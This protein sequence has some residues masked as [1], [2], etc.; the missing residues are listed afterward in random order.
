MAD[1]KR[2]RA[3]LRH[4]HVTRMAPK[5]TEQV[6]DGG[7]LYWVVKGMISARQEIL[8]LEPFVDADGIGRCKIWLGRDGGRGRAAADARLP[9]LALLSGE[10]RAAGHRR[11]PARLRRDAGGDAPRAGVA[12]APCSRRRTQDLAQNIY[13]TPE[14]FDGYS[15][16]DRSVRGLDG[17]SR[18]AGLARASARSARETAA[19]SRL[20]LRL[21]RP[22]G[23]EPGRGRACSASIS[24]KTCWRG[25][26]RRPPIRACAISGPIWKAW[27]CRR[28]L[29]TSPIARL[30]SIMWRTL[31]RLVGAVFRA[32]VPGG[33]FVFSIEHPIYMASM[34]PGWLTTEDGGR[35][36]PVDHYAVEGAR[37][38]DWLA[39][40]VRKQHRTLGTTLNTLDRRRLRHS[41]RRGMEPNART[42]RGSAF[43][44]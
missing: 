26:G 43:P 27:N 39:K 19:R 12:R 44:G 33:H 28:R 37:V 3:P 30:P 4:A 14:F 36:W 2:R 5:R 41:A 9:G 11:G 22:M 17:G 13:D 35:T 29:S 15:R 31:A 25:R 32:L 20:R 6:L 7:S 16:L 10:G 40:G 42:G 21:D 18:M 8:G 23:D 34:K 24:P 1:A 38:T